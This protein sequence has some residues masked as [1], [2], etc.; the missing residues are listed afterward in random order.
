LAAQEV[1]GNGELGLYYNVAIYFERRMAATDQVCL[2]VCVCV[3][4]RAC[5]DRA[6]T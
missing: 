2:C 4:V 3:R 1:G 6:G 5:G